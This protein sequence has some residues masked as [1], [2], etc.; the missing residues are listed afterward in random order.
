MATLVKIAYRNLLRHKR[1]T[2]LTGIVISFG[3]WMY[4]FMD[5]VMNGLDRGS[6]DNMI[7]LSTSAV[8]I[9]TKEYDDDKEAL[10]LKY[11]LTNIQEIEKTLATSDRVKST[12]PRTRFLGELSNYEEA[13]PVVGTVIAPGRDTTVFS[14]TEYLVG[15]YFSAANEREIILGKELARDLKVEPGDNITLYALTRYE[16]RNADDFKVV[17]LFNTTD[18]ALNKSGVFI[19]FAAANDLLDLENTV[20]ELNVQL[21]HRINFDDLLED[22]RGV[23]TLVKEKFPSVTAYSFEELGA[24][25]LELVRQKKLWGAGMTFVFLLIAAVG[26][27]N[28]VLMSV[29]ERIRE[30]GVLRALGMEGR[31]IMKMFMCEGVMIGFAGSLTGIILGIA[32]V[33]VLTTYGYPL[34]KIY[35]EMYVDTTG[36]PVWGTIYGEWNIPLIIGSFLFGITTAFLAS[37][38]PARKAATIEVTHALRFT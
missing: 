36:F 33:I 22:M 7:H 19:T 26:I 2:I 20:T 18:P 38:P 10:P 1:R 16:S 29:Y 11:G 6:M 34:D 31:E 32:T 27:V 25:I 13:M 28:S 3:L 23:Q 37:I 35:G 4:I 9:H 12:T 5:S 15:E 17:G 14:L 24:G 30:V 8:K 21:K